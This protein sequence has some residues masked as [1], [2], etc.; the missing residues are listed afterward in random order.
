MVDVANWTVEQGHQVDM[1]VLAPV[2]QYKDQIDSRIRVVPLRSPRLWIAIPSLM[3]YLW[4]ERPKVMLALDEGCHIAAFVARTLTGAR[5]RIV[6]RVGTMLTMLYAT[7][8]G[9]KNRTR[10]LLLH[11]LYPHADAAIAVSAAVADDLVRNFDI[12]ANKVVTI[13]NP[14]DLVELKRSADAPLNH[15]WLAPGHEVPVVVGVG[16]FRELKGFGE[17]IE[18]FA[19]VRSN[20]PCRLILVGD[21]RDKP[22]LEGIT[23]KLG[24]AND[25]DFAGYQ[26][27]PHA[28]V[29][30][31]DLFVLASHWEGM[32]NSLVEA[33]ICGTPAV[34]T[35]CNGP[36]EVMAPDTDPLIK[37]QEGTE[38]T[39]CGILVPVGGIEEMALAIGRMLSDPALRS[40][41]AAAATERSKQYEK[42]AIIRQ[43]IGTLI[44]Y[45]KLRI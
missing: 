34:A 5:T 33:L 31:A 3:L 28:Y 41:C 6:I 15:P 20:L 42:A 13:A 14:K 8:S 39:P 7:R 37:I 45:K 30:R 1:V 21:G 36:R 25:V 43:Y 44:H 38:Q 2:G 35:D 29:A 18:A 26:D 16:R 12:P 10:S 11:V 9:V 22:R 40:R 23:Q 27:N 4:R 17:L 19:K 32:P 24:V